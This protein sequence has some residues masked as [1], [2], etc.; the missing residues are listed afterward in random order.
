M[1]DFCENKDL[2]VTR[3]LKDLPKDKEEILAKFKV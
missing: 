3:H 1:P 2:C